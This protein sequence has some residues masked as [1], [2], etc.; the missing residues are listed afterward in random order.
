[1]NSHAD[2]TPP[3]EDALSQVARGLAEAYERLGELLKQQ[4]KAVLGRQADAIWEN[5]ERLGHELR[6]LRQLI[7]QYEELVA[8]GAELA[9]A[10][11]RKLRDL[12]SRTRGQAQFNEQLLGDRLAYLEFLLQ[13]LHEEEGTCYDVRGKKQPHD[14]PGARFD[15]Q[16]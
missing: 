16:V 10:M 8:A 6:C 14:D 15:E 3:A 12:Q 1:M 11:R 13:A 7:V 2:K 5:T 9:P 4:R